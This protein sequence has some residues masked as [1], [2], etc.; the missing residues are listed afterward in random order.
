MNDKDRSLSQ[1]KRRLRL[2]EAIGSK[3]QIIEKCKYSLTEYCE[4]F[5]VICVDAAGYGCIDFESEHEL[6]CVEYIY[7]RIL[8][9]A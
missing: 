9:N 1:L 5:Y 4:L 2:G 7:E 8:E 6:E 3:R